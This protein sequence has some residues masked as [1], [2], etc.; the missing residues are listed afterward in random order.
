MSERA[1]SEKSVRKYCI[2]SPSFPI[3]FCTAH[4]EWCR[5]VEDETERT[6]SMAIFRNSAKFCK[7]LSTSSFKLTRPQPLLSPFPL[8][9]SATE[10]KL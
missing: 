3:Q 10:L 9:L 8:R 5:G 1:R 2:E 7:N 6:L 4:S